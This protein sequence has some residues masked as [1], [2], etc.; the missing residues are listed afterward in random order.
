MHGTFGN[1]GNVGFGSGFLALV[2]SGHVV[3]L[4]EGLHG[5]GDVAAVPCTP[6]PALQWLHGAVQDP[7]VRSL[8]APLLSVLVYPPPI[9]APQLRRRRAQIGSNS[10]GTP[11]F[12][13]DALH[14]SRPSLVSV[15]LSQSLAAS[16]AHT[17]L[18]NDVPVLDV[19]N[20]LARGQSF[21]LRIA[22]SPLPASQ[23]YAA[24]LDFSSR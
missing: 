9:I 5:A 16:A 3:L 2:G 23:S 18:G 10:G 8:A 22:K 13:G 24:T 21:L 7:D 19:S 20:R 4:T 6:S 15:Q 12:V 11:D 1:C 14:V 17:V